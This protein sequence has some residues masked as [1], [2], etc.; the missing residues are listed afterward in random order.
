MPSSMI[1]LLA[2]YKYNPKANVEF[3]IGNVAPDSVSEWKAKDKTHF[4]DREDRK[5]ALK[6][7]AATMN[8]NSEINQGILLHLFLDFHWDSEPMSNFKKGY[9]N[10]D[11]FKPYRNEIALAGAWLFHNTK[12]SRDIWED[13]IKYPETLYEQIPGVVKEDVTDFLI[14][15]NKWHLENNIGP[16]TVFT[17]SFV[18]EFTD[19]VVAD[20]REWLIKIYK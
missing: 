20:F 9:K 15:N 14:R 8:L 16:S 5:E 11:W 18:E 19:K 10:N 13:M 7:L 3:W 2:A 4:R 17:P 12:W 6:E 1:H